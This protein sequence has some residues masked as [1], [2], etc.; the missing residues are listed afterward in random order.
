MP[1]KFGGFGSAPANK[2]VWQTPAGKQEAS[3]EQKDHE[4]LHADHDE[5]QDD[6]EDPDI[7][8]LP[9]EVI[10]F[11]EAPLRGWVRP[12]EQQPELPPQIVLEATTEIASGD[13]VVV[14][15]LK[16][17]PQLN[18]LTGVVEEALGDGRWRVVLDSDLIGDKSLKAQNLRKF[19][20]GF[21]KA[22]LT[23]KKDSKQSTESAPSAVRRVRR[24]ALPGSCPPPPEGTA[25][26]AILKSARP[27]WR[28]KDCVLAQEKLGKVGIKTAFDL[29]LAVKTKSKTDLN[30]RLKAVGEKAFAASTL[31]AFA[32]PAVADPK[33]SSSAAAA[34]SAQIFPAHK[35]EVIHDMAN[36]R[37]DPSLTS[38]ALE[39]KSRGDVV[40]AC[41]ESFDG[42][43]RLDGE[44]GWMMKDMKG[45]LGVGALL[46]PLG[47]PAVQAYDG[48]LEFATQLFEVVYKHVAVRASPLKNAMML[49]LKMQGEEVVASFQTYDGWVYV[50]ELDGWMLSSDAQLGQLLRHIEPL[51]E[52]FE[53][54]EVM[55]ADEFAG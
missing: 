51:E 44:P 5:T 55:D 35:F 6:V 49:Q 54:D 9:G 2:F 45:M 19:I 24:T 37:E 18:N 3:A 13:H 32:N 26:K 11:P 28:E 33:S 25:L 34:K 23:Q 47:K 22:A 7:E 8:G 46:S 39:R 14:Q 52:E 17:N 50:P 53:D 21:Q 12:G 27:D 41:L 40:G 30:T 31:Q 38:R 20:P 42:W 10:P 29:L 16:S 15:N 1:P 43:L 48:P 4:E 36:V